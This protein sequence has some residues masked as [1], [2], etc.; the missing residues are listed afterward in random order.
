MIGQLVAAVVGIFVFI[1]GA[2]ISAMIRNEYAE[3]AR[4]LA[5]LLVKLVGVLNPGFRDEWLAELL[6]MHKEEDK[7]GLVFALSLVVGIPLLWFHTAHDTLFAVHPQPS[8]PR[9]Q[10]VLKRAFDVAASI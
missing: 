10:L 2:G 4:P 5:A 9:T 8:A 3:W 1:V 7:H 6:Y